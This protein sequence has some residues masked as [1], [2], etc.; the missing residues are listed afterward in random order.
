MLPTIFTVGLSC[1]L[2]L[3]LILQENLTL[4]PMHCQENKLQFFLSTFTFL[5]EKNL[6]TP[7][8]QVARNLIF[9][10]ALN[11][12][13]ADWREQFKA[14]LTKELPNPLAGS[15]DQP[16]IGTWTSAE[17]SPFLTSLSQYLLYVCLLPSLPC[18]VWSINQLKVTCLLP[19]IIMIRRWRPIS[20]WALPATWIHAITEGIKCS[21]PLVV[22]DKWLPVT[23]D[24][25][26]AY[27]MYG[28]TQWTTLILL[29]RKKLAA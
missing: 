24:I 7:I 25:W 8:L 5:Q 10:G 17:I 11:W 18:K 29:C 12:T 26:G 16:K 19:T 2:I 6:P 28:K 21:A 15:T 4:Q 3:L 27:P 22:R 23:P 9:W 13:S 20:S 1:L 14:S